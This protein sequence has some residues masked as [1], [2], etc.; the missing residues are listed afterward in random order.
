MRCWPAVAQ[1]IIS[2]LKPD[3]DQAFLGAAKDTQSKKD[4][5]AASDPI[6]D[7]LTQASDTLKRAHH[8]AA[9]LRF[10]DCL[11]TVNEAIPVVPPNY[12]VPCHALRA[13][14]PFSL[15]TR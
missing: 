8:E 6:G 1:G 14:A 4:V 9:L 2:Y 15:G 3:R 10:D 11:K 12:K 7:I 5:C 13:Y